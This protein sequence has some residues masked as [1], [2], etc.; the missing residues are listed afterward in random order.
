MDREDEVVH[1][2]LN[3]SLAVMNHIRVNLWSQLDKEANEA[4]EV[5]LV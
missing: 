3:G 4:S 2:V 5:K 1:K